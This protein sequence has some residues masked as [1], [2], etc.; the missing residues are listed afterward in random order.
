MSF[1]YDD[2]IVRT[3]SGALDLDYYRAE[4]NRVRSE[5]LLSWVKSA[6][7]KTKGFFIA[8]AKSKGSPVDNFLLQ[9]MVK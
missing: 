1:Q 7:S 6:Y 4:A 9:K 3:E 2:T 8:M 5:L